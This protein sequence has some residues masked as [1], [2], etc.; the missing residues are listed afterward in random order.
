MGF[1]FEANSFTPEI[2]SLPPAQLQKSVFETGPQEV[3]YVDGRNILIDDTPNNGVHIY[4]NTPVMTDEEA[5][6]V[7]ITAYMEA[8][9]IPHI[10]R[11]LCV[12]AGLIV[13]YTHLDETCEEWPDYWSDFDSR[14]NRQQAE[15]I[16]QN[17][18]VYLP[19]IKLIFT[20][21]ELE[22]YESAF[23]QENIDLEATEMSHI[24]N[25]FGVALAH[26][27][28]LEDGPDDESEA[29]DFN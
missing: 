23:D 20:K 19:V 27:S 3:W 10:V 18:D 6:D 24:L 25:R 22:Y 14:F 16:T 7:L 15:R 8:E 28:L 13:D 26:L 29:S 1:D 21:A 5:V 9:E 17:S 4:K 11:L 2:D 12:N